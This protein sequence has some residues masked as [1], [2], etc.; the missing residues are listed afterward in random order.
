M[1]VT[2]NYFGITNGTTCYCA[3]TTLTTLGSGSAVSDSKCN[4]ACEGDITETRCGSSK[5][6]SIWDLASA[7]GTSIVIPY[8]PQS[9]SFCQQ[10]N[11]Y[12]ANITSDAAALI[13]S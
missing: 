6:I 13:V 9:G 3:G 4:T 7:T 2:D 11:H 5:Y 1:F 12:L 10:D 8:F